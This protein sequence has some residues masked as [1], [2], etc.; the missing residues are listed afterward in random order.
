MNTSRTFTFENQDHTLGNILQYEL[1]RD[2]RVTFAAYR[3]EHPNT[4][5]I[6][7]RI[8]VHP[9][10]NCTPQSVLID[11]IK[12]ARDYVMQLFGDVIQINT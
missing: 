3:Q 12:K 2:P 4:R 9:N 7:L 1:L 6:Y 8:D 5:K 11:A 10:S